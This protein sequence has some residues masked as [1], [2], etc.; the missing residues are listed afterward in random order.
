MYGLKSDWTIPI[1]ILFIFISVI[2]IGIYQLN[3][4]GNPWYFGKEPVY[5]WDFLIKESE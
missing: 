3:S 1:I 2:G 4:D 5:Q